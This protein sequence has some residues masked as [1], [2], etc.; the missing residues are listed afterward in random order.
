M[1]YKHMRNG[2]LRSIK[3]TLGH[4]GKGQSRPSESGS[5]R[6]VA[7]AFDFGLG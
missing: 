4:G 7:F 3:D 1:G 5:E 2:D 6:D